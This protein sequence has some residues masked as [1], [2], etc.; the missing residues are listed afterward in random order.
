[1]QFHSNP[2]CQRNQGFTLIEVMITVVII[3]IL[4]AVALPAY[5]DYVTRGKIPEATN[6]LATM[7]IQLEQY[8]QDNRSYAKDGGDCGIAVPQGKNFGFECNTNGQTYKVTATGKGG[9]SEFKY[10]INEAGSRQ[11]IGL[12]TKWGTA[13]ESSPIACWVTTKGGGC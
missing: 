4:A 12:P 5:T 11:T 8:Y 3:S 13:S 10:T 2:A 1:M 9:I 6:G 7:R